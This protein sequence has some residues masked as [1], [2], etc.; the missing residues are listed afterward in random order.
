MAHTWLLS[1]RKTFPWTAL[2]KL[3][4]SFLGNGS[5]AG[6]NNLILMNQ[7]NWKLL[8]CTFQESLAAQRRRRCLSMPECEN[9][10]VPSKK[11][12]SVLYCR[13][14]VLYAL[15]KACMCVCP[16]SNF[17]FLCFSLSRARVRR[18][19]KVFACAGEERVRHAVRRDENQAKY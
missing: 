19:T 12:G 14:R 1:R 4:L 17:G 7:E 3:L 16:R 18:E 6:G 11:R 2:L 15:E 10:C 13:T 8:C 9:G 5:L